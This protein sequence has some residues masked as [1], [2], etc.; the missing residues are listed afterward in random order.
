[1][2]K[3]NCIQMLG[4][5][6]LF[7]GSY[8]TSAQFVFLT[9]NRNVGFAVVT[10]GVLAHGQTNYPS[11]T[12]ADLSSS[13][14]AS[15]N[16]GPGNTLSANS[17][18][19][20]SLRTNMISVHNAVGLVSSFVPSPPPSTYTFGENTFDVAFSVQTPTK[21]NL[22]GFVSITASPYAPLGTTLTSTHHGTIA[23]APGVPSGASTNWSYSGILQ[24]DTYELKANE[25]FIYQGFSFA[26]GQWESDVTIVAV[27][28]PEITAE[29]VTNDTVQLTVS[30]TAGS[31]NRVLT[32]TN[33]ANPL[34]AWQ[35]IS[36]N[37]AD[38]TG[39]FHSTNSL[40]PGQDTG[41]YLISSP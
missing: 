34:S 8:R 41:F 26:Q 22:T 18:Q 29:V 38:G 25:S 21:I 31:T 5:L 2:K 37:V 7:A 27:P 4:L 23:T 20:S 12:F 36:T 24:P 9:D 11:T 40:P 32:T 3:S 13:P 6:A 19:T 17:S 10:N 30:T 16:V 15:V 14:G 33:L 35:P 1:M 39:V 28:S